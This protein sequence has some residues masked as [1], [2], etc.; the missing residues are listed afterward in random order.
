M[1]HDRYSKGKGPPKKR[2]RPRRRWFTSSFASIASWDGNLADTCVMAINYGQGDENEPSKGYE[3]YI[4]ALV[5][6]LVAA[7]F[8]AGRLATRFSNKK[9]GI[10]DYMI[11]TSLVSP[12]PLYIH[13][14]DANIRNE[15]VSPKA[16]PGRNVC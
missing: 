12:P 16:P 6:V 3:L 8:V 5:M 1:I 15:H 13:T 9:V 14:D 11:I 10:D 7:V 4:T 2:V